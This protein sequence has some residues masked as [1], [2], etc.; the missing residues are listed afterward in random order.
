V[1][2][3]AGDG[4]LARVRLPGGRLRAGQVGAVARAASLGNG[5]VD[6]TARANLQ[7]RGL[8]R[9]AAAPLAAVLVPAGL[10]PSAAHDRVRNVLASPV[11]GRHPAAVA[12][13]DEVVAALDRGLCADPA[14]AS[15]PSRF[16]F[17]VDDGS[18]VAVD[19]RADVTLVARSAEVFALVAGGR[20]ELVAAGEAAEAALAAARELRGGA[21]PT[22]E[23]RS[24]RGEL[25][26]T[27]GAPVAGLHRALPL[28]PGR[29]AQRDGRFAITALVPLGSLDVAALEGLAAL[30]REVRLGTGRTITV[31]DVDRGEVARI[32]RAL[33]GVGL[34]LEPA[35]GWVGLTA[36]AGLGRCPKA[37]LDVRAVAAARARGRRPGDEHWSACERRCGERPGTPLAVWAS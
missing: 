36:C 4:W 30:D 25:R 24:A 9:E 32:E 1:L 35:S 29:L 19:A 13:T 21:S 3:E 2:H 27:G 17:A 10:V 11:A 34:V 33:T 20:T 5:L 28:A 26:S 12:E 8:A 16:L 14:L 22:G 37:R 23:L 15:L 18:G 6:V 31:V 7:V